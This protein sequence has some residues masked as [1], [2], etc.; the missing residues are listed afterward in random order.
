[1]I[2]AVLVLSVI[3]LV[4]F[5]VRGA[6]GAASAIVFNAMFIT[7][8]ALGLAGPLTI[9]DGLYWLALAN[10]T[11]GVLM[12][13]SLAKSLELEP[14]TVLYLAGSIPTNVAFSV[15]LTRLD[16]DTALSIGLAVVVLLSGAYMAARPKLPPAE[17]RTVNRLALP[18]GLL[19]GVMGGLFGMSG[20]IGL[21][22]FSRATDDPTLFRMR[23]T[24]ITATAGLVR[25]VAL[26]TQDVYTAERLV[27]AAWT[28]PAVAIGLA[29]GFRVHRFI[30]PAPFR[31]AL[32][33]LVAFSGGVTLLNVVV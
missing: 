26:S 8:H 13:G 5:F 1:M 2:D 31:F 3:A 21:L 22:L 32:G 7:L 9:Q 23:L 27:T 17:M 20:P 15:F 14:L 12:L 18:V 11:A 4:S 6:T 29:L 24:I 10:A 33:T 16:N 19:A 30:R 25:L 28:L